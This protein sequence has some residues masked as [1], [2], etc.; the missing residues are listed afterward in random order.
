MIYNPHQFVLHRRGLE[1]ELVRRL[2][3]NNGAYRREITYVHIK[4]QRAKNNAM[5]YSVRHL[6]FGKKLPNQ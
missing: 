3:I 5:R 1:A 6:Y 2:D 4:Q